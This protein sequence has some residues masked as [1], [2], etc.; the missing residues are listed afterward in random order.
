MTSSHLRSQRI[1]SRPEFSDFRDFVVCSRLG[2][3]NLD[4]P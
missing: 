2:R 1:G 3:D 4:V